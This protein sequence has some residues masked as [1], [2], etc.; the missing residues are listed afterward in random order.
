MKYAFYFYSLQSVFILLFFFFIK[1]RSA[2]LIES[3]YSYRFKNNISY[4]IMNNLNLN[5]FFFC[6]YISF[7]LICELVFQIDQSTKVDLIKNGLLSFS[8]C[9]LSISKFV[10]LFVY[11][12]IVQ[13]VCNVCLF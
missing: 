4:F 10:Y 12:L 6:L 1:S 2:S 13:L 7:W 9:S 11:K 3:F 5:F 8:R